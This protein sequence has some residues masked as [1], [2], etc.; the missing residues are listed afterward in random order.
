MFCGRNR[1]SAQGD[2]LPAITVSLQPGSESDEDSIL[3]GIPSSCPSLSIIQGLIKELD[4]SYM[5]SYIFF[6]FPT[7][8]LYVVVIHVFNQS[9]KLIN[10]ISYCLCVCYYRLCA[11]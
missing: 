4:F 6:P 2:R 8:H 5:R 9:F 10:G 3:S 7:G 1:R 11:V